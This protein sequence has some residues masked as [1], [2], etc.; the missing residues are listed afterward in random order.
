MAA[1][2]E[3]FEP[4]IV[5][6]VA[7]NRLNHICAPASVDRDSC[8]V[9][10]FLQ[11]P[12][13][14]IR[15][16]GVDCPNPIFS[17]DEALLPPELMQV[18]R[19]NEWLDPTPIQAVALPIALCGRDLIGIAKTGS[20]KTGAF[21]IP[22]ILHVMQNQDYGSPG[23]YA[24]VVC[25]TR[26]L[27]QQ[28]HQVFTP[29]G[30][31]M[32]LNTV[33]LYGGE[34]TRRDQGRQ[35]QSGPPIVIATPGRLMNL[36]RARDLSLSKVS[37]LVIDE[38]DNM[39][40]MGFMAQ[41]RMILQ[42]CQPGRQMLMW[43]ATWPREVRDLADEFLGKGRILVVIG[44]TERTVNPSIQQQIIEVEERLKLDT[45]MQVLGD[46]HEETG[47]CMKVILFMNTKKKVNEL[48]GR[49]TGRKNMAIYELCGD[50]SR[51]Q[52]DASVERFR[53]AKGN[54]CLVATAV[55]QR[56]MNVEDVTHVILYDMPDD[57]DDYVH[58]IGRTARAD[59]T[60]KSIAF[61]SRMKD[62]PLS[63]K[64]VKV[65]KQAQQPVPDW[66]NELAEETDVGAYQE[67]RSRRS[68]Y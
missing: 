62:Q 65:L 33:C 5:P 43:S 36:I 42:Y 17:F 14:K 49:L 60:G 34:G 30:Q 40:T 25:P 56:G 20:G 2:L 54:C 68:R 13:R 32:N 23:P 26:E 31:A 29:F 52:R 37:F 11:D 50:M 39:L 7:F 66:L 46:L 4:E 24:L 59:R 53:R 67:L 47:G 35:C 1:F 22:A 27:A 55:A 28:I 41:L 9:N 10:A 64:L 45:L 12:S 51:A 19:A 18:I 21:A 58:R 15:T 3:S 6:E 8:E 57:I 44:A 61:F 63:R 16:L 38:A 48:A